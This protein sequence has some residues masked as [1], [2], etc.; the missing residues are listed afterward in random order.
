MAF[1]RLASVLFP[2]FMNRREP[3]VRLPLEQPGACFVNAFTTYLEEL[4]LPSKNEKGI[5]PPNIISE[6]GLTQTSQL[7]RLWL[8]P[9]DLPPEKYEILF[10]ASRRVNPT[11]HEASSV[12][13]A[14]YIQSAFMKNEGQAYLIVA[15]TG[16]SGMSREA[17]YAITDDAGGDKVTVQALHGKDLAIC[18]HFL[19]R[20]YSHDGAQV[21]VDPP[22]PPGGDDALAKIKALQLADA[23]KRSRVNGSIVTFR[24]DMLYR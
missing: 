22:P 9:I 20:I 15:D 23:I 19:N 24:K 5:Y 8:L 1:E 16:A 4:H 14:V 10:S 18:I 7:H 11:N 17:L 12:T 6:D 13:D 2:R 3:A 21:A